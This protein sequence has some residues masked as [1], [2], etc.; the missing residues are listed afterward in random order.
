LLGDTLRLRGGTLA[1]DGTVECALSLRIRTSAR[2]GTI[3]ASLAFDSTEFSYV[4]A[5]P[6]A[7]VL[8]GSL[9]VQPPANPGHP[10]IVLV[11]N[12]SANNEW[13][14]GEHT[15][16]LVRFRTVNNAAA[17]PLFRISLRDVTV[18]RD[19]ANDPS[20]GALDAVVFAS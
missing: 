8:A 18:S 14:A 20:F 12:A 10:V 9:I 19:N 4:G 17:K 15:V 3:Q 13:T 6:G 7:D 5:S 11:Q 2:I 1:A 16:A